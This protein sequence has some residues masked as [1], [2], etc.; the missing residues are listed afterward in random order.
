MK[1]HFSNYARTQIKKG[2]FK[3]TK[4]V[5]VIF[6]KKN[7]VHRVLILKWT[8][9]WEVHFFTYS[10]TRLYILFLV[11]KQQVNDIINNFYVKNAN[12][13]SKRI[14]LVRDMSKTFPKTI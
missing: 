5:N 14:I 10:I 6:R 8:N 1:L 2:N 12:E 9:A 3:I 4:T 11:L 7:N 13:L